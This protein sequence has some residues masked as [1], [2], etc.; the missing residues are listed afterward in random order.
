[1]DWQMMQSFEFTIV[2][3][4]VDHEA[5]DFEDRFFAA[6]CDDATI[7]FSRGAI[8]LHFARTADNFEAAIESALRGTLT[9]GPLAGYPLADIGATVIGGSFHPVDSSEL[10]FRAATSA[11]LHKAYG[12]GVFELLEPIMEGE[13]ITPAEYLGEV[14]EDLARRRGEILHTI[15]GTVPNL[16]DMPSGCTF[17]NRCDV[18][19][20][21]CPREYP[22]TFI[23]RPGHQVRCW[24]YAP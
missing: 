22:P 17:H 21:I 15:P 4:G 13:V 8:L 1:T 20:D 14:M 5:E 16:R 24:R 23:P 7:A 10:A 19:M 6:G 3:S 12:A 2:A 9:N 18:V 11:A